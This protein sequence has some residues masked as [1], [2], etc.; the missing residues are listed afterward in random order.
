M[1][2]FLSV[3]L[4]AGLIACKPGETIATDVIDETTT[5]PEFTQDA[6]DTPTTTPLL[7]VP[8]V[9]LIVSDGA[10]PYVA[11]Q[12]QMAL[13]TLAPES[14]LSLVVAESLA[15]ELITPNIR[16]V[17]GVG[18][19]VDLTQTA[20][21]HPETVFVA[22][23][24]SGGSPTENLSVIGDSS[25]GLQRQTFMAGYLAAL[26]TSDFKAAVLAPSDSE[27]T[28]TIINTFVIGARFFCGNCQPKYPPYNA[29]PQWELIASGDAVDGY[30]PAIDSLIA[31][32]VEVIYVHHSVAS[33]ELLTALEDAGVK[34]ISDQ[35]PDF[36]RSNWVGTVTLD[37]A[38]ALTALWPDLLSGSAG[39]QIPGAVVL[40]DRDLGLVSEGRYRLFAEMVADLQSGLVSTEFVP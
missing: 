25:I 15:E 12:V 22:I 10:D 26:M 31:K 30:Q 23:D 3:L 36:P 28:D 4:I 38:V 8:A 16:V 13:E 21:I 14:E 7:E 1:T 5:V 35:S 20:A 11:A 18:E 19:G 29:F 39:V 33:R 27:D 37:P 9:L 24:Q 17:V 2:G 34:V 40:M 6:T 32:G